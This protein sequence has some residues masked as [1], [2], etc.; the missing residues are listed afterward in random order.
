MENLVETNSI[1][2]FTIN[3]SVGN[4]NGNSEQDIIIN[5]YQIQQP[6]INAFTRRLGNRDEINI[7]KVL[8]KIEDNLLVTIDSPSI[9]DMGNYYVGK[10]AI[11]SGKSIRS[12]EVGI[13]NNKMSSDLVI[14]NTVAHIAGYATKQALAEKGIEFDGEIVV[15]VDMTTSLPT[16]QYTKENSDRFSKRFEG[17]HKVTVHLGSK[18][19]SVIVNFE[20]VKTI[21]EGVTAAFALSNI[22]NKDLFNEFNEKYKMDV[23][24]DYFKNKKI[25]HVAIGEG[26]TEYPITKGL[27]FNPEFI[28][29]SNN[30]VGHAIEKSL[31]EF[32]DTAHLE[33]CS[34]QLYSSIFL[35]K[36]HKYN[37]I[38]TEILGD[39]LYEQAEEIIRYTK[40]ELQKA[41]GD[42]DIICVYGGG[43]IAMRK[44][45]HDGLDELCKLNKVQLFY[46]PSKYA[47]ILESI[48]L[49]EF[50]NGPIFKKIKEL[51]K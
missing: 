33:K 23:N 32:Q 4:D 44:Q 30:G 39:Y 25:L 42:V 19:V 29:G 48:G 40:K 37:E 34:R 7:E 13:D 36:N 47:V 11:N 15:N 45:I 17:K 2:I 9:T 16:K 28:F 14:I 38:A 3:C 24:N 31:D 12:I 51:K 46:V 18:R 22:T 10:Y 50:T 49:S 6:N 27:V 41:N 5:G 8:E 26:T 20:T 35:D 21:P 43:S 1:E